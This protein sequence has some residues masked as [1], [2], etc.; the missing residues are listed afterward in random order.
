MIEM[1]FT[2]AHDAFD[3]VKT[4]DL[5]KILS[6]LIDNAID[7]TIEL[8]E[9]ERKITIGCTADDTHYVFKITNTGPRL[10]TMHIFSNKGIQQKKQSKGK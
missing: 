10:W 2:I 6:N 1:D 8:P 9:G 3:K 5:I 7:A 4:T